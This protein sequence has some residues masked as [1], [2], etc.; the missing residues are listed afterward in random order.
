M[1]RR[2][3]AGNVLITE[4]GQ[5][6]LA[7]Y[8]PQS[9]T[10]THALPNNWTSPEVTHGSALSPCTDIY[11]F[12]MLLQRLLHHHKHPGNAASLHALVNLCTRTT[13]EQRPNA[14][15]IMNHPLLGLT[16]NK[17]EIEGIK[18]WSLL[19]LA[20]RSFNVMGNYGI[21]EGDTWYDT[22]EVWWKSVRPSTTASMVTKHAIS[23]KS[24][25]STFTKK[26][27][28]AFSKLKVIK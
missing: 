16:L 7:D 24:R 11:S 6:K 13:P 3:H 18:E 17:T 22:D 20:W 23:V 14:R 19:V 9:N 27:L 21:Q 5:I 10:T 4:T 8:L 28:D 2:L 26:C 25:A 1:S 12:G 15:T